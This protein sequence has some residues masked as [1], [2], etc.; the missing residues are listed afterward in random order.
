MVDW[1]RWRHGLQGILSQVWLACIDSPRLRVL[2]FESRNACGRSAKSL[3]LQEI[4]VLRLS[5]LGA[6]PR[7]F[8][9]SCYWFLYRHYQCTSLVAL[10]HQTKHV[11][12]LDRP[13][14]HCRSSA[15]RMDRCAGILA[16]QEVLQSGH[17]A[18][19]ESMKT[20][21]LQSVRRAS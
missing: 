2:S 7:H 16:P 12:P 14:L 5:Q 19:S 15:P 8:N 21:G 3:N 17:A 1:Q 4:R 18:P 9:D 13:N 6:C 10:I 11:A 20:T